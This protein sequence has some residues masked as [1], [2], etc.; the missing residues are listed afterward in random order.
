MNAPAPGADAGPAVPELRRSMSGGSQATPRGLAALRSIFTG[1]T[2]RKVRSARSA[3]PAPPSTERSGSFE[4]VR[5]AEEEAAGRGANGAEPR[6]PR[7]ATAGGDSGSLP[8]DSPSPD[9]APPVD[10]SESGGPC[11]RVLFSGCEQGRVCVW[12]VSAWSADNRAPAAAATAEPPFAAGA[13]DSPSRPA[14]DAGLRLDGVVRGGFAPVLDPW[15]AFGEPLFTVHALAEPVWQIVLP[16]QNAPPPWH[17]CAPL[18]VSP[19]AMPCSKLTDLSSCL[20]HAGIMLLQRTS[21][22]PAA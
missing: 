19:S 1:Q 3:H 5:P 2:L 15:S 12:G 8:P 6:E 18:P 4:Q 7:Q 21:R 20:V 11:Q 10:I 16:P 22:H 9:M 13:A 14:T 17:Q